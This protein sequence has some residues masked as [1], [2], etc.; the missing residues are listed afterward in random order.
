MTAGPGDRSAALTLVHDQAPATALTELAAAV[1]HVETAHRLG[2]PPGPVT[3]PNGATV[4]DQQARLW[5]TQHT[6]RLRAL[7]DQITAQLPH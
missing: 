2:I 3:L 6:A 4:S 5:A 7:L 1:R